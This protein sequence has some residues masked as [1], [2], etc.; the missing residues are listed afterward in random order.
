MSARE[1][2]DAEITALTT[3]CLLVTKAMCKAI[4]THGL[5]VTTEIADS[6]SKSL[7]VS[8]T[9]SFIAGRLPLHKFH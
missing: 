5:P 4:A 7:S 3:L 2:T 6:I 8:L 1:V 9:D